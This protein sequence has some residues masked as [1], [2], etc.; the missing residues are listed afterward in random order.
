MK[1]T[2]EQLIEAMESLIETN[3][4]DDGYIRLVVTRGCGTLGLHPFRCPEPQTFIIADTIQLYPKE[5]YDNGMSVIVASTIRN[6]PNALSPRIKSLNY[7]NN[8]LAKIE[9]IDAGVPEA[10]M[11]N[12]EGLVAEAT[13]DNV[14]IVRDDRL[15]T[16]P[17]S[18]GILEGVTRKV[19]MELAEQMGV[20]V[21]EQDVTRYDLYS[22]QE[23]FLTGTAAEVIAVTEIDGRTIADGSVG[24]VTRKLLDAF[25]KYVRSEA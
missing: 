3:D 25:H 2:G 17:V 10:I 13:G 4:L 22:C 20:E 8:V 5:M 1:Y 14:F 7:L 11:L 15:I 12:T 9:A 23:C 24:P 21:V 18:A 16:P 6:H 19:V